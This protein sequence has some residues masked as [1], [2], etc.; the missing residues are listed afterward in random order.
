MDKMIGDYKQSNNCPIPVT[1]FTL[2]QGSECLMVQE[3]YQ[4]G[5]E[6]AT[7][8][9]THIQLDQNATQ[10]TLQKEIIGGKEFLTRGCL[11]PE[12]DIV[13]FRSTFLVTNPNTRA[14]SFYL[15]L[16]LLST[17]LQYFC[18]RPRRFLSFW[19]RPCFLLFLIFFLSFYLCS[20]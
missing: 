18:Y 20:F 3:R 4:R 11:L 5:D 1:W 13:G 8:T 19:R 9:S 15:L 16:Y 7:H 14:V 10:A 6:L 12:Q 17:L 2:V